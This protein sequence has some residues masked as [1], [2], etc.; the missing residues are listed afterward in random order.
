MSNHPH[1]GEAFELEMQ[2]LARWNDVGAAAATLGTLG[3]GYGGLSGYQKARQEGK[4]VGESL[5]SAAK[6]VAV[7]GAIGAGAGGGLGGASRLIRGAKDVQY[8]GSGATPLHASLDKVIGDFGRRQ[9][10]SVT[11]YVGGAKDPA[12]R[13]Q[14]LKDIGI[15]GRDWEGGA[16]AARAGADKMRAGG[17]PRSWRSPIS[18]L[19]QGSRQWLADRAAV[20]EA[21]SLEHNKYLIEHGGTSIPGMA[22]ALWHGDTRGKT[23]KAMGHGAVSGG[24]TLGKAFLGM[25]AYDTAKAVVGDPS[26]GEEN[27]GKGER[28]GGALANMGTG[29]LPFPMALAGQE[30]AR[31][32]LSTV[33][34]GAGRLVDSALG[35]PRPAPPPRKLQDL[36]APEIST[37]RQAQ[38]ARMSSPSAEG[39]PFG[40]GFDGESSGGM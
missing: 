14:Y 30:I 39:K 29:F 23:L 5:G 31:R 27:M 3:A 38:T 15:H 18:W 34:R 25:G 33:G 28:I 1:I 36:T 17:V 6:G 32:G 26:P 8:L 20:S 10:H 13:I 2:K 24:G 22:G 40:S 12:A 11:G 37:A 16:A 19:P 9:V 7:G 4:G 21:K 35:T